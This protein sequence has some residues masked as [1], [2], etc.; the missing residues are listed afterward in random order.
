MIFFKKNT[1]SKE[2]KKY[3]QFLAYDM[4][5]E[6]NENSLP[7]MEEYL[8][9]CR[10]G[11][12]IYSMQFAAAQ[13]GEA[14]DHFILDGCS[15]CFALSVDYADHYLI[16]YNEELPLD[17]R[18]WCIARAIALIKLG[19]LDNSPNEYFSIQRDV[20]HS[21]EFSYYFTCPDV[22]LN[23]CGIKKS[24]D[25]I[26]YCKIPFSYANKKSQYMAKATPSKA[27]RMLEEVIK[28]NF[29]A[30]IQVFHANSENSLNE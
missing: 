24:T 22:I 19:I 2:E 18:R 13:C 4:L 12:R 16:L 5:V 14:E 6:L 17:K 11:I 28:K 9:A 26:K 20:I 1:L 30:F 7:V 29:S 3:M 23:E 27:F 25:I 15:E 10:N 21:T 8:S